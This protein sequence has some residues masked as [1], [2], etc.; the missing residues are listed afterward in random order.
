[1]SV[2]RIAIQYCFQFEDQP[3]EIFDL[4]LDP[5][6][7][8]LVEV[9][10]DPP[11]DWTR[12][13]F[14]QCKNCPLRVDDHPRCPVAL[15]MVHPVGRFAKI[16]SH[17]QVRLTVITKERTSV[18]ET[19]AQEGLSS[20]LGL[21]MASSGCPHTAYFRPMARFHLPMASSEETVY[22]AITM[23]LLAQ[24]YLRQAGQESDFDLE[25]LKK[26]YENLEKVNADFCQRLRAATEQDSTLNAVVLLDFFAKT[27]P[28]GL[29][30]LLDEM[31]PL[32]ETS[33]LKDI[34]R[35][36]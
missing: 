3:E 25:G 18:Q 1:V 23:Y 33:F 9:S 34:P 35:P 29:E 12:L 15:N 30:T 2:S 22:R 10:P 14:Q 32:F 4:Q 20:L 21:I 7:L 5:D 31:R 13:D 8:E 28:F 19:T 11:P 17:S 6:T 27:L 26:L 24:Y 36:S 16:V